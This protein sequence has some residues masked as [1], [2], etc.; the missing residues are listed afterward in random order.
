MIE[1][2]QGSFCSRGYVCSAGTWWVKVLTGG[3]SYRLQS[4][5]LPCFLQRSP[6]LAMH[7][8][9]EKPACP[10]WPRSVTQLEIYDGDIVPLK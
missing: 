7:L 2:S 8:R 10:K 4:K 9:P 6:C 1:V 5:P 3:Q